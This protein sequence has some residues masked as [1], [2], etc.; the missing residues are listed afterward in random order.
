M[1]EPAMGEEG[2]VQA[3]MFGL[4]GLVTAD[5]RPDRKW[6]AQCHREGLPWLPDDTSC[7]RCLEESLHHGM[8]SLAVSLSEW[9]LLSPLP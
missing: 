8:M 1:C 9:T 5:C 6:Q 3:S 4:L 7:P 2:S